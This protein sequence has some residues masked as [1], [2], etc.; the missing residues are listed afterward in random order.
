MFIQRPLLTSMV[1]AVDRQ[2]E[3]KSMAMLWLTAYLFLLR[4]PSEGLPMAR[5]GYRTFPENEQSVFYLESEFTVCVKLAS[6]KNQARGATIRRSC[7]C[8]EGRAMRDP[9]CPIHTLWN[10]FFAE[11]DPNTKPWASL[12][13]GTVRARL[14]QTLQRLAVSCFTYSHYAFHLPLYLGAR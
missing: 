6:R 14:R 11:L 9:L 13:P 3:E 7:T 5:G 1:L 8:V 10:E 4:V 2:I 12:S